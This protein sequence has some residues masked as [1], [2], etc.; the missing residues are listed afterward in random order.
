MADFRLAAKTLGEARCALERFGGV[1][2]SDF[3]IFIATFLSKAVNAGT[4]ELP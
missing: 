3:A 2:F 4:A 1:G